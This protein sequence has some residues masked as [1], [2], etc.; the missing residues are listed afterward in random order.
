MPVEDLVLILDTCED[1]PDGFLSRFTKVWGTECLYRGYSNM[2]PS[3]MDIM[4][5][6]AVGRFVVVRTMVSYKTKD[7]QYLRA[8]ERVCEKFASYGHLYFSKSTSVPHC[9]E[10]DMENLLA[11]YV[12]KTIGLYKGDFDG[13]RLRLSVEGRGSKPVCF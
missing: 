1:G 9:T 10:S 7:S 13:C 6:C 4:S 12:D 2:I 3:I 11:A 8:I 5:I